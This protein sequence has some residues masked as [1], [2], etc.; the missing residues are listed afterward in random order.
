[1]FELS[2][3]HIMK[4]LNNREAQFYQR[5]PRSLKEGNIDQTATTGQNPP[6]PRVSPA[7]WFMTGQWE[8]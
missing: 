8:M 7:S 4:P 6:P 5:F 1:M 2:S 3:S